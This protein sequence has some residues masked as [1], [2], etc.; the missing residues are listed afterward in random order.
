MPKII[1]PVSKDSFTSATISVDG[2]GRIFSA[3][4]GSAG[5]Q[6]YQ[7][8]EFRQGSDSFTYGAVDTNATKGAG[9]IS[10]GGGGGGRSNQGA[11]AR[12]GGHG[13]FG[14]WGVDLSPGTMNGQS[15]QVGAGGGGGGS[16]QAG[17]AGGASNF[18]N[19]VN[20][21]GGGGGA[22]PHTPDSPR[23]SAGSTNTPNVFNYSTGDFS[24]STTNIAPP[25]AGS[26]GNSSNGPN[27]EVSRF[28]VGGSGG[29]STNGS[30]TGGAGYIYIFEQV[31]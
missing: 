10:G 26:G 7:L 22:S 4:A 1:K 28:T 9:I 16:G 21:G 30:G 14:V 13:F 19:V 8:T 5:A 12:P 27:A 6:G 18:G 3:A 15:V 20:A 29:S 17:Q 24:P 11:G 2:Q 31:T 25:A 23:P